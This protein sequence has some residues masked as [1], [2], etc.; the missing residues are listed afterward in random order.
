MVFDADERP[1]DAIALALGQHVPILVADRVLQEAA[2][3]MEDMAP[4]REHVLPE[5]RGWR[6]EEPTQL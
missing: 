4:E 2:M 5:L 3:R 6:P 1:S